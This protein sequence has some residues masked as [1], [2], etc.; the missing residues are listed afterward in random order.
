[1]TAHAAHTTECIKT[2]VTDCRLEFHQKQVLW[3]ILTSFED[4]QRCWCRQHISGSIPDFA[5]HDSHS[6]SES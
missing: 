3:V 5:A 1:M 2:T 6:F 4:A